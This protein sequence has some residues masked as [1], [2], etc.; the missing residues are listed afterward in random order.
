MNQHCNNYLD[1]KIFTTKE[2]IKIRF[3]QKGLGQSYQSIK[4]LYDK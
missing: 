4:N 2:G 3:N 1:G